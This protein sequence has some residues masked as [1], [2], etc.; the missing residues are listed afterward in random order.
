MPAAAASPTAS[1][2]SS[3][4]TARARSAGAAASVID[5]RGP[6][7]AHL[8]QRLQ[9]CS[10]GAW[11]A[12]SGTLSAGVPAVGFGDPVFEGDL[13]PP[14]KR[15]GRGARVDRAAIEF[16]RAQRFELRLDA[17]PRRAL[18]SVEELEHGHLL[19]PADVEGPG[20]FAVG[21]EQECAHDV[22]DMDVVARRL[23][24]T[25]GDRGLA[26]QE[27]IAEDRDD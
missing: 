15:F 27:A 10:G 9:R 8:V 23:A 2:S 18:Q 1:A 5:A 17:R 11:A 4:T 16:A 7:S 3:G 25:V 22:G 19:P 6:G 14:A 21:G 12:G 20:A 24:I 13:G 26:A